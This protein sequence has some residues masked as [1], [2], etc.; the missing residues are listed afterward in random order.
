MRRLTDGDRVLAD[1]VPLM[2]QVSVAAE[3]LC[4]MEGFCACRAEFVGRKEKPDNFGIR[5]AEQSR[6]LG[7]LI[8]AEKPLLCPETLFGSLQVQRQGPGWLAMVS[9]SNYYN[10]YVSL[11]ANNTGNALPTSGSNGYWAVLSS[12][13][14][15]G[16]QE[17]QGPQ[18]ATGVTGPTGA[19][20][21][22]GTGS[23][24]S[25][26]GAS[27]VGV[28]YSII[29]HSL[30]TSTYYASPVGPVQST[31]LQSML[32]SLAP[33]ACTPSMT[34][35]SF[36]VSGGTFSLIQVTPS[37]SSSTYTAGNSIMSCSVG[38]STNSA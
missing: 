12:Q 1:Q 36:G 4:A 3:S 29:A 9:D 10:S 34:I 18:G 32:I 15:Q 14:A 23:G 24:T 21:S 30:G 35:Y 38:A 26:T 22:T 19:T 7:C 17:A 13:G 27:P 33:T 6:D 20:G 8:Q 11:V 5:M 2:K 28:P 31:T 25:A 16:M 37:S